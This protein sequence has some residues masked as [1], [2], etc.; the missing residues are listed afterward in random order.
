[1]QV[2]ARRATGQIVAFA[3]NHASSLP[4]VS[5]AV[6]AVHLADSQA[7]F[8]VRRPVRPRCPALA[9]GVMFLF[10]PGQYGVTRR[11]SQSTRA[12]RRCARSRSRT[13]RPCLIANGAARAATK[14]KRVVGDEGGED[15][16]S[17]ISLK[18]MGRFVRSIVF[19][20]SRDFLIFSLHDFLADSLLK[21]S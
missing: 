14:A 16:S 20:F 13:R 2:W 1:M 9:H 8:C 4:C 10:F 15:A 17:E 21:L 7:R 11:P 18:F 12:S 6:H 19:F 5:I 3:I